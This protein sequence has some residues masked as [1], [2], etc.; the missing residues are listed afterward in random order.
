MKR[1]HILT[2]LAIAG[3]FLT[4]C[5]K[6]E[7]PVADINPS[8]PNPDLKTSTVTTDTLK[9]YKNLNMIGPAGGL[10]I[11]QDLI[12]KAYVTPD[13]TYARLNDDYNNSIQ[14]F[15]LPKGYQVV[16]ADSVNGRGESICYVAAKS[17]INQNLPD[18]LKNKVSFI[19]YMPIKYAKKLGTGYPSWDGIIGMGSSWFYDWGY[20]KYSLYNPNQMYAPM[21]W[22]K[23]SYDQ[24][25]IDTLISKTTV[26]HVLGFNEP[27]NPNQSNTTPQDAIAYYKNL[28]KTGLRTGSPVTQE[29]NAFGTGKWLT[30][31]M[32]LA[33][34]D[35]VRVDVITIHWYDWANWNATGNANPNPQDVLTRFQNYI[36]A[37]HNAYPDKPIWITEFNA[38][39]NRTSSQ[40]HQDFMTLATAWLNSQSYVERYAYFF[41]SSLPPVDSAGNLTPIGQTWH[42]LNTSTTPSVYTSNV[43]PN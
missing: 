18:R 42:D 4:A 30:T 31:F 39:K 37:V 28:L 14:S 6:K 32:N 1:N 24:G 33:N 8:S 19:R 36:T 12:Y 5:S 41:P 29:G 27:D 22:G 3:L 26:D 20:L 23:K 9:V 17:A 11:L 35:K 13:A 40:I 10:G 38:N 21:A 16:F 15:Y 43:I 34:Q 7:T 25:S 2:G